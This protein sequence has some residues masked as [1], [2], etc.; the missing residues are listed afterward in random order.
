MRD[1]MLFFF[2]ISFTRTVLVFLVSLLVHLSFSVS[3]F[4][5]EELTA[6]VRTLLMET[7]ANKQAEIEAL[8]IQSC[9]SSCVSFKS[10]QGS[11]FKLVIDT[12]RSEP[13]LSFT[14]DSRTLTIPSLSYVESLIGSSRES[15]NPLSIVAEQE[16]GKPESSPEELSSLIHRWLVGHEL[17]PYSGGFSLLKPSQAIALEASLE[18]L[19]EHQKEQSS[20]KH[21]PHSEWKNSGF[22]TNL[23]GANR[24]IFQW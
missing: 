23:N 20:L 6:F 1:N 4:A 13:E 10:S 21:S 3:S 15:G 18:I 17:H 11:E 14:R 19:K 22:G 9:S 8:N 16:R 7:S 5:E 2:K 12:D 24:N